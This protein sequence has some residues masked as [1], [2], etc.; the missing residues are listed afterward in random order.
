[1]NVSQSFVVKTFIVKTFPRLAA[2]L[3]VAL[4]AGPFASPQT[5][6]QADPIPRDGVLESRL[7][8]ARALFDA[9]AWVE[10]Q[11]LAGE[12]TRSEPDEWRAWRFLGEA[13]RALERRPQAID[14]FIK[15]E[16]RRPP[17]RRGGDDTLLV[18]V[19]DL[20]AAERRW[21]EAESAYL[22]ALE[23]N[24]R[25]TETWRKLSDL[26]LLMAEDEPFR[27]E[28][29]ADTLERVL[30]MPPFI[31]DYERWRKLAGL[32]DALGDDDKAHDA[33]LNSVRLK[34]DDAEA[35]ENIVRYELAAG[36]NKN[37]LAATRNLLKADPNNVLANVRMGEDALKKGFRDDAKQRFELAANSPSGDAAAR[38]AA[39]S[40]LIEM[41]ESRAE[42][43]RLHKAILR[44]DPAQW[45]SW[46]YVIV[47]LRGQNLRD[48]AAALLR[49][50]GRARTLVDEDKPV[51]P[52]LLP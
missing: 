13:E 39:H 47:H 7:S 17:V 44:V 11:L 37:A 43:L 52:E 14:A 2:A 16:N 34:P 21:P 32:R 9:G 41:A 36:R 30:H 8:K 5:F 19:A 26:R 6:A 1:M 27:R 46:D 12:W 51:P 4:C 29:A 25:N 3:T 22:S 31:N 35:W 28:T 33:Y 42:K 18:A 40:R 38:T 23:K 45:E 24:N 15:A 20:L 48:E 10:L 50:K 49:R